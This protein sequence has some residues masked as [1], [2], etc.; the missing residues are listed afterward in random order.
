MEAGDTSSSPF[1]LAQDG[2]GPSGMRQ[3][4][5]RAIFGVDRELN[6][7]EMMARASALPGIKR[8][9]RMPEEDGASLDALR[10]VF[11]A[12][13]YREGEMRM[14]R[15]TATVEFVQGGSVVLAVQTEGGFRP[16]VRETLMVVARELALL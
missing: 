5:L 14:V 15:G 13:G 16:G 9:I 10:R 12:L 6:E 1:A 3:L 4:E 11:D 8:L 7:S 2:A